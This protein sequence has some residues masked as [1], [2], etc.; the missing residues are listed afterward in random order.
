MFGAEPSLME[1][2]MASREEPSCGS[3]G[4]VESKVRK[5]AEPWSDFNES[6]EFLFNKILQLTEILCI[7]SW[8]ELK[9]LLKLHQRSV[10]D[11]PQNLE[12]PLRDKDQA[13]QGY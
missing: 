7:I 1:F 4:T 11:G 13:F 6:L 9:W 8:Y 5:E 2:C 10:E 12:P 3:I